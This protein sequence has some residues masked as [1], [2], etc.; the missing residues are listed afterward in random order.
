MT[1]A[2]LSLRAQAARVPLPRLAAFVVASASFVFTFVTAG[3]PIPLFNTY[4]AQDGITNGD[5]GMVSVGYFVAAAAALLVL[6][7]LSNHLG[8]RPVGLTA[9]ASALLS[10]AVLASAHGFIALMVA[11]RS[12]RFGLRSRAERPRI[13][14]RRFRTGA[15]TLVARGHH[16]QRADDRHSRRCVGIR[17]ARRIRARAENAHLRDHWDLAGRVCCPTRAQPGDDN[18]TP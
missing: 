14:R 18:A 4:R 12:A 17:L 16:R 9:L 10:C 7:R 6:G 5:L 2:S 3:S 11:A 1:A 8:R 13:V 15:T